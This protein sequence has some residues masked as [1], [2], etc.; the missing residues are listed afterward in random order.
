MLKGLSRRFFLGACASAVTGAAHLPWLR[1][2]SATEASHSAPVKHVILLWLNGGPA[3]IDLWDLKP[4]HKNGGPF[5]EISTATPGV[6]ISEHLPRLARHTENIAIVRS[7]QSREGDHNRAAH[8]IRTGYVPQAGIDF[9]SAG[10]LVTSRI[11]G[12]GGLLPGYISITPPVARDLPGNG[13]LGPASAPM[14]VGKNAKA[15]SDLVVKDLRPS[16]GEPAAPGQMQLLKEWN[17]GFVASHRHPLASQFESAANRAIGA[18]HPQAVAAFDLTAEADRDRARYGAGVFGQGC[19]LARRLVE[20]GVSFVEVSLDGW[21]THSDNFNRVRTLTQQ[22]DAAFASL[23]EDLSSRSMLESTLIVCMGE[24]GRTPTI[25]RNQGRDH[26]PGVWAAVLAGGG[27]GR[28]QVVGKTS[29]DGAQVESQPYA[30]PDLIATIC[31]AA[32]IDHT[33]QNQSNVDRPI[34]IAAPEARLIKELT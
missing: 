29:K 8:L 9:P 31:H 34:R 2:L 22:L 13:F 12:A 6:R 4:A 10:A 25:N 23:L 11:A 26:W 19:L 3:T 30:P 14:Y 20:R 33:L 7:M 32:G 16:E 21:D 17:R 24:F 18:M 15:V 1:Q 28:G 27:V 5:R